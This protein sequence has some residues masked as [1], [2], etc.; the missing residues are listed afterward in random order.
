MFAKAGEAEEIFHAFGT[1][2]KFRETPCFLCVKAFCGGFFLF[3][4]SI[5]LLISGQMFIAQQ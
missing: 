1:D 3:K 4:Y 5:N 2:S